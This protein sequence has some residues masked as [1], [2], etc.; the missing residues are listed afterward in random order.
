LRQPA[1]APQTPSQSDS[2]SNTNRANATSAG[3]HPVSESSR[4]DMAAV[5][6]PEPAPRRVT[7]SDGQK[8]TVPALVGLP[9]RK[10]I[11]ITAADGLQVQI[12]GS[13]TVREQAPAPGTQVPTGTKVIVRCGR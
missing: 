8:L 10:V 4:T 11:E 12:D 13:G 7:I 2:E 6:P 5:L 3:E 9:V 1:S